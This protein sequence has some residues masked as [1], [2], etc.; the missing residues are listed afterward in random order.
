MPQQ[1]VQDEARADDDERDVA[2]SRRPRFETNAIPG[3][4]QG[5]H[6]DAPGHELQGSCAQRFAQ[7]ME[8]RQARE[9]GGDVQPGSGAGPDRV[10]AVIV[11]GNL[12]AQAWAKAAGA[13][14]ARFQT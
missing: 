7:V 2:P 5:A 9:P 4:Q 14:A 8:L 3:A 13:G 12:G 1:A 11:S 6:R 10:P